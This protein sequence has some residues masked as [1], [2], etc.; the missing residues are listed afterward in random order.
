[1]GTVSLEEM[2]FEMDAY[3]K[4]YVHRASGGWRVSVDMHVNATGAK[5]EIGSDFDHATPSEAATV[6]LQRM[7]DVLGGLR[8]VK[9]LQA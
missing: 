7:R 2:L 3:G 4:P 1:M 6:C 5:F 9:R 8:S